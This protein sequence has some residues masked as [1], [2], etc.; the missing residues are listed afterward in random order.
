M[1]TR[2]VRPVMSMA[3]VAILAIGL[4]PRPSAHEENIHR[5]ITA[6]ALEYLAAQHPEL[7]ACSTDQIRTRLNAGVTAEDAFDP[8]VPLGHFMY[9]FSPVLDDVAANN[10]QTHVY[11]TCSSF[12]GTGDLGFDWAFDGGPCDQ[13]VGPVFWSNEVNPFRRGR[14]LSD[15]RGYPRTIQK[16]RGQ[17][18]LGHFVHLLQDLTSPPHV[19]VDAHPPTDFA[20]LGLFGAD[21]GDPSRYEA[22]NKSAWDAQ[23]FSQLTLP[24]EPVVTD[25]RAAF[26]DLRALT[27]THSMSEKAARAL[28]LDN[29]PPGTQMMCLNPNDPTS[30]GYLADQ[31]GHLLARVQSGTKPASFTI[32]DVV[33]KRQFEYLAPLAVVYTAAVLRNVQQQ[34]PLCEQDIEV[35]IEGSGG[36][37]ALGSVSRPDQ[38]LNPI[39]CDDQGGRCAAS[40][41]SGTQSN[42][43]AF[44]GSESLFLGWSID[45]NTTSTCPSG[46]GGTLPSSAWICPIKFDG[47]K[48]I[49]VKA[50]FLPKPFLYKGSVSGVAPSDYAHFMNGQDFL[51]CR[52]VADWSA[53]LTVRHQPGGRE[54]ASVFVTRVMTNVTPMLNAQGGSICPIPTGYSMQDGAVDIPVTFNGDSF[55]A[56][57]DRPD[58]KVDIVGVRTSGGQEAQGSI[59]VTYQAPGSTWRGTLVRPFTLTAQ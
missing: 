40:F 17:I 56:G 31:D 59:T 11:S 41:P 30:C 2:R 24:N 5:L 14:V 12:R 26:N 13:H 15:L 8:F 34:A 7:R 38:V 19:S 58:F 33:A 27:Q 10:F 42:L 16:T 44:P 6:R 54:I 1:V 22:F 32:D 55:S 52:I 28:R 3:I 51:A 48:P 49:K 23:A 4:A 43:Y 37:Q 46:S 47:D 36:V 53:N 39:T 20:F 25:L 50:R 29:L 9:H 45:Q 35:Q 57:V 18:G 21:F